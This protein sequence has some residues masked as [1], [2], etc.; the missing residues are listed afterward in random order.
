MANSLADYPPRNEHSRD[1]MCQRHLV[2]SI[3]LHVS[4]YTLQPQKDLNEYSFIPQE[5]TGIPVPTKN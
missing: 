5:G 1:V 4:S 2:D 3:V